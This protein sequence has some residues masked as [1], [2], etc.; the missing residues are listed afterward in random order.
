MAFSAFDDKLEEP[1]VSELRSM[2]GR[3]SAHWEELVAH[4]E[5]EYAPLDKTWTF[6]GA[7]W[8]WSLR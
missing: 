1:K 7:K 5:A 3:S 6:A 4:I 8:G 2:L